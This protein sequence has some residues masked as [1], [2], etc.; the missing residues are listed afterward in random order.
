M[1]VCAT[2]PHDLL[3]DMPSRQLARF[4]HSLLLIADIVDL[5]IPVIG[6]WH[7]ISTLKQ[8]ALRMSQHVC[9]DPFISRLPRSM[10]PLIIKLVPESHNDPRYI[11]I[12]IQ[13]VS[14]DSATETHTP[15]FTHVAKD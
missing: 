3:G 4:L 11:S 2:A 15:V 14:E 12:S 6:A 1:Y 5:R 13:I 9:A 7:L 8:A 10:Q